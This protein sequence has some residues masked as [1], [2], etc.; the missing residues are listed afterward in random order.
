MKT[1]SEWL[2]E[3]LVTKADCRQGDDQSNFGGA[4]SDLPAGKRKRPPAKMPVAEAGMVSGSGPAN[5][6]DYFTAGAP[7]RQEK[8]K[9]KKTKPKMD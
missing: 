4:C 8:T 1:F 6:Q 7:G 3:A 9:A 2:S 5:T